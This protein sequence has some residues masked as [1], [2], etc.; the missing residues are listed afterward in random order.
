MLRRV[1]VRAWVAVVV[2]PTEPSRAVGAG[3]LLGH[4]R[5]LGREQL[6]QAGVVGEQLHHRLADA[7][8]A[9][10]LLALQQLVPQQEADGHPGGAGPGGAARAVEVGGVVLG[11]VVVDDHVDAVDVEA[12]GGHVGGDEHA[13][14]VLPEVAKGTEAGVL[15]QVAVE[16]AGLDALPAQLQ[17]EPVGAPLGAAEDQ[18]AAGA[19]GDGRRHLHLVELVDLEE[20][21]LHLLHRGLHRL[22]LVAD[23][24]VGVVAHQAVDLGVEG[25]GE[26]HRLVVGRDPVEQPHHLG[27]EAHVGHA[28]GLVEDEDGDVGHRHVAPLAEVDEASGRGHH[29]VVA[30]A[31]GLDLALHG[32]APEHR[33]HRAVGG[34]AQG[35][36]DV[37]H[38]HRQLPGGDEDE[39]R[40]PAR[41]GLG[42]LHEEGESEGQGLARAGLGL[43]ADVVAGEGVG[44]GEGL[45]R[46]GSGDAGRLEGGDQSGR[47]PQFVERG[48]GG[49]FHEG[50]V[51]PVD[52]VGTVGRPGIAGDR[53][54]RPAGGRMTPVMAHEATST[55]QCSG[56]DRPT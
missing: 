36:E 41:L 3:G 4:R 37:A 48:R 35:D 29:H 32:R 10:H 40:G 1:R 47:H 43:A 52:V 5:P 44:D 21:V 16:H 23:R 34:V 51:A 55:S 45:D 18:G 2:V 42:D 53:R 8:A 12:A 13:Q 17:L 19:L 28:V 25:G 33:G 50:G 6:G 20:A 24:V 56:N 9:A 14:P 31:D 38:L 54:R 39:A 7:Q 27:H 46:K 15:G 49:G 26:E 22:D 30:L 11:R